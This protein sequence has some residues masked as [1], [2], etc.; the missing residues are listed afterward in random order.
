MNILW[1]DVGDRVGGLLG[2]DEAAVAQIAER[3]DVDPESLR[4]IMHRRAWQFDL[5]A[6]AAIIRLY[7]LDPSWVLTGRYDSVTHRTALDANTDEIAV[8]LAS[9]TSRPDDQTGP[10]AGR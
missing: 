4:S 2:Q 9:L 3:L 1:S 7:G 10:L 5:R 8:T 6:L